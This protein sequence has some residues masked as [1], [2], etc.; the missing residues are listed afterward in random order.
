MT[1]E[2][3]WSAHM[4]LQAISGFKQRLRE[5]EENRTKLCVAADK[6]S[7]GMNIVHIY[8]PSEKLMDLIFNETKKEIEQRLA[9]AQKEF[10]EL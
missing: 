6:S 8:Y 10:D 5:L 4:A 3:F 7:I 2:K 1:E 9:Q